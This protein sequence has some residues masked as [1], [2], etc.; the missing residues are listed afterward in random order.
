[1]WF[2]TL[3]I[4]YSGKDMKESLD[5]TFYESTRE[6]R[7]FVDEQIIRFNHKQ[8]PFQQE[9][10]YMSLDF[11][12]KAENGD[13]IAG[14]NATL[15]CWNIMYVDVL[16]VEES[17]R[18]RGYGKTLLSKAEAAA[19]QHGGYLSHLDTFDWQAKEFYEKI[20]YMVFGILDDCP[21]GHQRYFMKKNL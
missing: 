14:I 12:L 17:Y 7:I 6:D 9:Q 19:R 21:P 1:M 8:V 3:L 10:A 20:G 13:I 2:K 15:Y 5:M 16:Y 18:G 4:V 11:N